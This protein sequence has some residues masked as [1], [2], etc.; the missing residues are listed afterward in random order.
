M[1]AEAALGRRPNSPTVSTLD[2]LHPAGWYSPGVSE[3]QTDLSGR[4]DAG[5]VSETDALAPRRRPGEPHPYLLQ[6]NPPN[7]WILVLMTIFSLVMAAAV[8]AVTIVL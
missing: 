3:Q 1:R 8:L 7:L 2:S 6:R 4:M 5:E